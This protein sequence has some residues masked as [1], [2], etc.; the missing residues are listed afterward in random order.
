MTVKIS[1]SLVYLHPSLLRS[2]C[3]AARSP[4]NDRSLARSHLT[5]SLAINVGM[6]SL[7]LALL[8]IT[9]VD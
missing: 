6:K 5:L 3:F 9:V 8:E 2:L 7:V 4:L 1:D